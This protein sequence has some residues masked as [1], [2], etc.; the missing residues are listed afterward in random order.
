MALF[1][2]VKIDNAKN[3]DYD[4]TAAAKS[5][6]FIFIE[7]SQFFSSGGLLLSQLTLNYGLGPLIF[8][9]SIMF[10]F[11]IGASYSVLYAVATAWF[12]NHRS[13]IVGIIASG[14]GLGALVLV[15]IQTAV[16]NPNNL[17]NFTHPEVKNNIPKAFSVLGGFILCLQIIGF[18]L[19]REKHSDVEMSIEL[20]TIADSQTVETVTEN[21]KESIVRNY[22]T[23]E[24]L[25]TIDFYLAFLINFFNSA[26]TGL[27][28][29]TVKTYGRDCGFDNNFLVIVLT[30]SS[31]FNCLGR[32][33]WGI[34]GNRYSFKGPLIILQIEWA[35]LWFTYGFVTQVGGTAAKALFAIWTFLLYTCLAANFVLIPNLATR[36]FG[37]RSMP[38]IFGLLFAAMAPSTLILSGVIAHFDIRGQWVPIYCSGAGFAVIGLILTLFLRDPNGACTA[39]TNS[40]ARVCDCCRCDP[41]EED[42]W[43]KPETSDKKEFN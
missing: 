3:W 39:W 31:V 37:P 32:L 1:K 17:Q 27:T 24:A 41:K 21:E 36:I 19:L 43:N 33:T 15:P 22:T 12:P 8:T 26:L 28:S 6:F 2:E 9:S 42:I 29:S 34:I 11:G 30:L 7:Y 13:I 25:R 23:L 4:L 5:L 14:L 38:T 40:C 35:S 20:S 16:I 18:A 10:G